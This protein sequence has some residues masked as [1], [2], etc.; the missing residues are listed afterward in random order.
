[1]LQAPSFSLF[2]IVH[3]KT[4]SWKLRNSVLCGH[5]CII[6]VAAA[7]VA[8]KSKSSTETTARVA[9]TAMVAAAKR[10]RRI[11]ILERRVET[12]TLNDKNISFKNHFEN[13]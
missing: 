2:L 9:T 4:V 11:L 3:H 1:M 10:R 7:A 5:Y 6:A 8:T 12:A 13:L